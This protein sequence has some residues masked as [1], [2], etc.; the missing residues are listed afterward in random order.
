MSLFDEASGLII[1]RA[2]A[3]PELA[4][5]LR[6]MLSGILE[7]LPEPALESVP[8][9]EPVIVFSPA[10]EKAIDY[11]SESLQDLEPSLTQLP[12]LDVVATRL[13][14]KAKAA[15]WVARYG[16]ME[17]P[18]ALEERRVILHGARA[19]DCFVWLFDRNRVDPDETEMLREIAYQLL[20]EMQ[21]T[22]P[23]TSLP[24]AG[25]SG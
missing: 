21:A 16:Y 23:T 7:K 8:V 12:D 11:P 9:A 10:I 20:A 6:T 24:F 18:E 17:Q 14:L 22:Q 15:R 1:Q 5:V 3:D 13:S 4:A 19:L 2:E 25:R